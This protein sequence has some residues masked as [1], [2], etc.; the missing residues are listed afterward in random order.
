MSHLL[1]GAFASQAEADRAV[2]ELTNHNFPISDLSIITM[3]TSGHTSKESAADAG[4]GAVEGA[5]GGAV[6]GGAIGG[7]AGLLAGAG[8]IPALA[9]LFIGGPIVAAIG[10]TG[11]AAMAASGAITG[12]AA[13]A[14]AGGIIGALTKLG[15]SETDAQKYK[16]IIDEGGYLLAVPVEGER[17]AEA[18][19]IMQANHAQYLKTVSL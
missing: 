13:G 17:E 4:T 16:E 10:L 11:A 12:A 19:N 18:T 7:L 1:I 14:A 2:T 8:I 6:T 15:V 5:T 3:E 9:G